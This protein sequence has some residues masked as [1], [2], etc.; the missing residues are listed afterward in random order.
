MTFPQLAS[1]PGRRPAGVLAVA[2]LGVLAVACG[3]NR[4]LLDVDVRS[5]MDPDKLDHAYAAPPAVPFSTRLDSIAVNLVEG[6]QDFGAAQSATLDIGVDYENA[7]GTGN[8]R[9]TI[10]FSDDPA[11]APS[12]PPV[13]VLDVDLAPDS[14]TQ[15][16][17]TIE[18]DP[19]VLDLFSHKKFWMSVQMDWFPTGAEPLTGTLHISEVRVHLVSTLDLF[20]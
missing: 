4:V 7:T 5:F 12:T 1:W 13:A 19:R 11:T 6:F 18:A 15:A 2:L 16:A 9:F 20:G 10:Y 8:G 17:V 14:V 3:K